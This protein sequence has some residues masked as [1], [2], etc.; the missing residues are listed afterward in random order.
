MKTKLASRDWT[1]IV[2]AVGAV[3]A[4]VYFSYLPARAYLDGL[5]AELC[6]AEQSIRE[7]ETLGPAIA[8]T[9][10][11]YGTTAEYVE[12]WEASAPTEHELTAIFGR[13]NRLAEQSGATTTRLEPAPAVPLDT[14]CRLPVEMACAGSFTAICQ[15]L[16][17]V[18]SMEETVWIGEL[19]MEQNRKD[20][21][22]VHCELTLDIFADNPDGSDQADR[23]E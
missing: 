19:R 21:E 18:E 20:G 6:A 23:S 9:D 15:F 1:S 3:N 14:I 12:K 13:I 22:D 4:Y 16:R 7:V 11:Q 8:A 5:R 10:Q 17:A 2:L